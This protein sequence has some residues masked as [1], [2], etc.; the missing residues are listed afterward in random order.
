MFGYTVHQ[1][2]IDTNTLPILQNLV[3]WFDAADVNTVTESSGNVSQW[4]DKS[5][6]DHN[7]T[8]GTAS[9]QP[10]YVANAQNGL[11]AVRFNG[12]SD[13]LDLGSVVI[14]GTTGRTF[15]L[16]ANAVATGNTETMISLTTS[17]TTAERYDLN[18]QVSLRVQGGNIVYTVSVVGAAYV[19]TIRNAA[20][21]DCDVTD[22]RRDGVTMTV[23]TSS[24]EI[25]NT[26]TTG[27][28]RLGE[29]NIGTSWYEGDLYEVIMYDRELTNTE[30]ESVERY[31]AVK[32]G[33]TLA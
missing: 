24:S 15:F 19:V 6:N 8:Q 9:D 4:D 28:T 2:G 3:A 22:G 23:S 5:G 14:S 20:S 12:T 26:G 29:R 25:I 13:F 33:I 11:H 16:V 27:T 17:S 1:F 10:T 7:A 31:L 18:S 32:W 30:V 21:S